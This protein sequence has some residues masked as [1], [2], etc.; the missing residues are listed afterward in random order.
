MT[1]GDSGVCC[2]S[3][4]SISVSSTFGGE[5]AFTE[6]SGI[7]IWL[8]AGN[9]ISRSLTSPVR[10]VI[11]GFTRQALISVSAKQVYKAEPCISTT[12]HGNHTYP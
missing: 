6:T 1:R 4:S 10:T 7:F 8:V 5:S 9:G 12:F 3:I 2:C 11:E